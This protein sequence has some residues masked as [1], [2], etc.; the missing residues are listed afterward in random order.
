MATT[1]AFE[2]AQLSALTTVDA[3]GNVTTSTS[4]IANASGDLTFDSAADIILNVDGGDL[5]LYDDT[6]QFGRIANDGTDLVIEAYTADRSLLFKGLDDT[7]PITALS[8]DMSAS[9]AATFLDQVTIGGNLIH[10]GN[11]TIDAG[12]DITLDAAGGDIL[13]RDNGAHKASITMN[14]NVQL[15]AKGANEDILFRG[16][17]GGTPDTVITALTLDMSNDGRAT[18]NENVVI[19]GDLT[20]EGTSVTLNTTDLNVE[21]K[22]ITLNYHASN[23]TSASAGGAGI[24]IQDA[25][26]ASNDASILWDA[27]NDEFDISHDIKVAGSVG[28]TNIVTNKVVKFN[29]AIL[30]DSNI[31]D[32]G[33]KITLGSDTWASGGLVS[34]GG[35]TSPGA[36]G[37]YAYNASAFDHFGGGMRTWSWGSSSARGTYSF[38]QLKED[39]DDQQTALFIDTIGRVGINQGVPTYGLE[40]NNASTS[41]DGALYVNAALNGSGNGLVINSNTRTTNDNADLLLKVIDRSNNV[42]L[43]TTVSGKVGIGTD[44]PGASLEISNNLNVDAVFTGSISGTTLTVTAV[45][46]G[47]IAVGHRISDAS[48]EPNTKI[49]ALGTGTGGIGT[50]TINVSQTAVSQTLRSV[51][52]DKNVIRFT[53]RDS[54]MAGGTH[55]GMLEF[56]SSDSGNAG[57]KGFIGTTTETAS[58]DGRL[59][60]GTGTSG[61]VDATTKMVIT[62]DGKVGIGTDSPG[63][64]LVVRGDGARI[65]VESEDMEVA[66]LGRRGSSG[67]ALDSGYLRLRN[68]GVTAD[69]IVLDSDNVSWINGGSLGIGTDSPQPWAKLEVAGSAGAQTGANQA[70]YVRAS[71]A[72]ANEGVGIRLSAASGSHEAVGIIGMVNNASGN[73]GSMTF[74][75]YNLGA[76]IDEQMRIDNN[77]NVGIGT[78]NPQALLEISKTTT[79]LIS[80]GSGNQGA[81]LRLHHEAQW[82]SGYGTNPTNPD[83][84]GSIDFSTGDGSTGEGVKASIRTSVESYYN[85]NHLNFYTADGSSS[86]TMVERLSLQQNGR[87]VINRGTTEYEPTAGVVKNQFTVHTDYNATGTQHVSLSNLDGNWFDGAGGADSQYGMLFGYNNTTRGGLIYDHR[88]TEMMTMWSSYAPIRFMVPNAADGDGVPIDSNINTALTIDLGG[89]VGVN[90][91][92]PKANF[93]VDTGGSSDGFAVGGKNI[94]LNTTFQS[95]AQLEISLGDHQAC[96]V[97]VFLTGDWSGHSAMAFLG[98]YFIQNGANG[99]QEAGSIIRE[100]DHTGG[101][102][103]DYVSSMI[104]DGGNYDSFQIQFKLNTSSGTTSSNGMLT[105]QVMGQFDSIT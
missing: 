23:D 50:Y 87:V 92:A 57:V 47:A 94:S 53:D 7:T 104:Y 37:T 82:E 58:A 64:S 39:G 5:R 32:T 86:T 81:T 28:V 4:Q 60:F 49:I 16:V 22:N 99:Y 93:H 76:T 34:T 56:Y 62:S 8:I 84:L 80:G 95:G 67:A 75:T 71:T 63:D 101:P 43:S 65:T 73:A 26:D 14:N 40:V 97:K 41:N 13:F 2:L 88:G 66:M 33:S 77:G 36:I 78:T 9:G 35:I 91:E 30:D 72:T 11:L 69:G 85:T 1:K 55:L 20:V 90:T 103:A 45:T 68:Q 59:I 12:G 105:Y 51:P 70:F 27:G 15:S 18:F 6:V 96:Y 98:E 42:A 25:V 102:A 3:S 61:A 48:I 10:A 79:G 54:S 38:I 29:G 100:V 44:S 19:Q 89:D 21:D 46:S 83:F 52:S 24:T 74:H 31:T 17:K